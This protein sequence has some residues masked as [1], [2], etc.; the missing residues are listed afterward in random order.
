M[1]EVEPE[2]LVCALV[3]IVVVAVVE[4][5]VQQVLMPLVSEEPVLQV[6]PLSK[7]FCAKSAVLLAET[8]KP[9][10]DA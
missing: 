6:E 10:S 4:A 3:T 5:N 2:L 9:N 1:V 7:N 8:V